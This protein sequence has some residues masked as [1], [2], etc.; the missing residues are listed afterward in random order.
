MAP[1]KTTPASCQ[2]DRMLGIRTN[3]QQPV[4]RSPLR[5]QRRKSA[6]HFIQITSLPPTQRPCPM[7]GG[8]PRLP[9]GRVAWCD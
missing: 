5:S 9:E 7:R 4:Q 3:H 2:E 6:T 1:E 8:R